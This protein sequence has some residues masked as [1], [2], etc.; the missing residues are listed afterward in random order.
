[1]IQSWLNQYINYLDKVKV[2]SPESTYLAERMTPK[3]VLK[4]ASVIV[5]VEPRTT[6]CTEEII[7]KMRR[8]AMLVLI[9]TDAD[10]LHYLTDRYGECDRI[11]I[12]EA[13]AV[14][15]Q[16]VLQT[17]NIK[18][19]DVLVSGLPFITLDSKQTENI[20]R[21]IKA[22]LSKTGLFLTIQY[23]KMRKRHFQHV[24]NRVSI[25]REYRNVPPLYLFHCTM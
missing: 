12:V 24:F 11:L 19:V 22:V 21:E 6:G 17:L 5:E 16:D 2:I 18:E 1:M 13:D 8:D 25:K 10:M 7:R 20:L 23:T 4:A 3:D 14:D 15:L 9:E